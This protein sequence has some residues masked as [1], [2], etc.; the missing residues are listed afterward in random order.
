MWALNPYTVPIAQ[1]IAGLPLFSAMTLRIITF[2]VIVGITIYYTWRYAKKIC[3]DPLKSLIGIL[4]NSAD[5]KDEL[6]PPFTV[7]HKLILN[8]VG[9]A[10]L[11]FVFLQL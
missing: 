7:R 2:I 11:F 4:E 5:S 9:L 10:L 6:I 8:F 1:S 3:H